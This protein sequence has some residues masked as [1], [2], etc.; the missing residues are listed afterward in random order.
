MFSYCPGYLAV[1]TQTRKEARSSQAS[2]WKL[3]CSG[4]RPPS[5]FPGAQRSPAAAAQTQDGL[6]CF[7]ARLK[8]QPGLKMAANTKLTA[9][10]ARGIFQKQK[11]P[12]CKVSRLPTRAQN[13]H[14]GEGPLSRDREQGELDWPVTNQLPAMP[15]RRA[16]EREK[17]K[18]QHFCD[19]ECFLKIT[20][21]K[22][23]KVSRM[24]DGNE[25]RKHGLADEGGFL[26]GGCIVRQLSMNITSLTVPLNGRMQSW[27]SSASAGGV[28][29]RT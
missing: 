28:T 2:L 17:N 1:Q 16:I 13:N 25:Y 4:C 22:R 3:W 26:N 12:P 15:G 18:T 11:C 20:S 6:G 29:A 14:G 24:F 21:T 9:G 27:P 19:T 23:G 10:R 5:R 8:P 7:E